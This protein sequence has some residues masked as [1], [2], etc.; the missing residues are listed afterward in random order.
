MNARR[1]VAGLIEI[2][3]N[4]IVHLGHGAHMLADAL[5]PDDDPTPTPGRWTAI[6][7]G[8]HIHTMPTRDAIEHTLSD[9]CPCGPALECLQ[10][11]RGDVWKVS[12]HQ[13][14]PEDEG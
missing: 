14:D 11:G 13:L 3:G 12:H 1:W 2:T 10:T 4:L 9:D 7:D 8:D 6:Q 5:D